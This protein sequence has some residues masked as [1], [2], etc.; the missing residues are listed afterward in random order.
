MPPGPMWAH[1]IILFR[2][3]SINTLASSSAGKAVLGL[4]GYHK[5]AVGG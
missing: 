5:A 4:E 2:H 3:C 1:L